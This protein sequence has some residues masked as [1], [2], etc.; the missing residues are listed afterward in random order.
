MRFVPLQ[1][2]FS[3]ETASQYVKGMSYRVRPGNDGLARLARRWLAEGKV[4][5]P[6]ERPGTQD[7]AVG[8]VGTV[9][10]APAKPG[11]IERIKSWL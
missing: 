7:A 9:S 2:F 1:D 11:L 5:V 6:E 3:P 4:F 10:N 8:G